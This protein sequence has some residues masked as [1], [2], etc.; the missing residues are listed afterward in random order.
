MAP[1]I[2][3]AYLHAPRCFGKKKKIKTYKQQS[4][5]QLY[6][7]NK[8]TNYMFRPSRGHLQADASKHQPEDNP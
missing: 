6:K 7:S 2:F 4:K 5:T 1:N 8:L 3:L